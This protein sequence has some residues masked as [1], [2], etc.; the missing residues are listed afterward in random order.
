MSCTWGVILKWKWLKVAVI[1]T[2]NLYSDTS[3]AWRSLKTRLWAEL[4]LQDRF[5]SVTSCISA[6]TS[7]KLSLP[8][9]FFSFPCFQ[10]TPAASCRTLVTEYIIS[11]QPTKPQEVLKSSSG[12]KSSSS[13]S[14]G[15]GEL[16]SSLI[17]RAGGSHSV[18]LNS[19]HQRLVWLSGLAGGVVTLKNRC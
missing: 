3:K 1:S 17:V 13:R 16:L 6:L 7:N 14:E 10:Q 5:I 9:F 18:H 4:I 19:P 2:P 8:P 15:A 11:G 12:I